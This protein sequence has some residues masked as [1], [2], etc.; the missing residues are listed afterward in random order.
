MSKLLTTNFMRLWKNK[1][2]YAFAIFMGSAG[3]ISTLRLMS[4]VANGSEATLSNSLFD[5]ATYILI[6]SSVFCSL[7]IGT[8]YSDGT[9]RN[10]VIMGYNRQNIYCA[11][12]IVCIAANLIMCL[13][14][15]LT[16]MVGITMGV[17]ASVTDTLIGLLCSFV[18]VCSISSLFVM[19]SM[20]SKRKT[21]AAVICIVLAFLLLFYAYEI[22]TELYLARFDGEINFFYEFLY[23]FLPGCQV[24]QLALDPEVVLETNP[25]I[26]LLCSCA[27]FVITSGVGLYLFKQKDL[28]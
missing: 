3:L 19:I 16:S 13:A 28:D 9:I 7:F 8:E 15:I 25:I 10:K 21:I 14:H 20:L 12:L 5:Y 6:F 26:I 11:N 2:F 23:A 4:H 18:M 1:L 24:L 17:T 22:R 27:L